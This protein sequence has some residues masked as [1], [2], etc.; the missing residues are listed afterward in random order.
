MNA[1]LSIAGYLGIPLARLSAEQMAN[2]DAVLA[3]TM[4]KQEVMGLGALAAFEKHR[5]EV[6]RY[7]PG[8]HG[9]LRDHQGVPQRRVL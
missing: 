4:N 3:R 9:S 2:L 8:S 6:A 1:K 7:A 5:K